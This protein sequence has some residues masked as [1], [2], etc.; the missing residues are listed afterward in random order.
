MSNV[1][2][3]SMNRAEPLHFTKIRDFGTISNISY[4][5]ML[6]ITA[7]RDGEE[8][9]KNVT[10]RDFRTF[11]S[12]VNT[13]QQWFIPIRDES[14][15]TW[16]W[17]D[18]A[19]LLKG[20]S[21]I[22]TLPD[23]DIAAMIPTVSSTEN[24]LMT[25]LDKSKLDN[26]AEYELPIATTE[27]LGGIKPDGQSVVVSDTGVL[28]AVTGMPMCTERVLNADGWDPDSYSQKI[29]LKVNVNNRNVIDYPPE[30]IQIVS[31]HHVLAIKEESDGITFQCDSIPVNDITVYVTSM[32]VIKNVN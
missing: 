18:T 17:T 11:F 23:I 24:G 20:A 5:D 16:K 19:S 26:L 15:I 21:T 31:Q 3:L 32:G 9:T 13:D 2:A 7:E 1:K 14:K 4:D 25:S 8:V 28:S 22:P 29:M 27:V 10:V 30:C 6:I 12:H